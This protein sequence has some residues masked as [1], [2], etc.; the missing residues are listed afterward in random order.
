MIYILGGLSALPLTLFTIYALA[1]LFVATCVASLVG[2]FITAIGLTIGGLIL[3][4][5]LLGA[6][7]LSMI[8]V[9]GYKVYHYWIPSSTTS[10]TSTSSLPP[11]SD[12]GQDKK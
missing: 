3:A 12:V 7:F 8:A 6:V 10:S 1:T 9:T 11:V 4:P 2:I 5:F